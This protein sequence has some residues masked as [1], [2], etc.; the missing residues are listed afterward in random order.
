MQRRGLLALP[1]AGLASRV[2]VAQTPPT[3]DNIDAALSRFKA[4]SSDTSYV[5]TNGTWRAEH[6]PVAPLFVGS[7]IKTFILTTYLQ[8]VEAGILS[9]DEQLPLND[10]V[11]SISS[12]S[13]LNLTGTLPARVALEQMIAHSDNTATDMALARVGVEKVRAFIA[14]AG[15]SGTL[16]PN[17]TRRLFSWLAGAAPGVD[18]GW[19]GC[20]SVMDGK[21]FG[22]V[23][24]PINDQQTMICP[25]ATFVAYY[26]RA[27]QGK[28][29]SKPATL[30]EFKRIQAMADAIPMIVPPDH[31]AWAKGGSIDWQDFHALCVPG[32]MLLGREPVTFCFTLNW[33]GPDSGVPAMMGG[34]KETVAN[35]M[36]EVAA[37]FG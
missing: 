35:V 4:L 26:Q 34:Y 17:S 25:A 31:V 10:S 15:L 3:T 5:I 16:I 20:Q 21:L 30:T 12:P 18:I 2:A 7:A 36:A 33:H 14:A 13:L 6:Q 23:R 9:E 11:R 32:Q 8:Q 29:F 22:P 27:L 24:S 1:A 19:A 37:A 28:F